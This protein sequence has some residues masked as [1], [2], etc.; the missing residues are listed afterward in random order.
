MESKYTVGIID[1]D[2]TSFTED[3]ES[4]LGKTCK[5]VSVT[6]DEI[7][8]MI[9]NNGVQCIFVI[10]KGYTDSFMEE[11]PDKLKTYYQEG[12]NYSNPILK[13]VKDYLSGAALIAS[14]S[15]D[16]ESFDWGMDEFQKEILQI[17]YLY[18]DSAYNSKTSAAITAFGYMAFCML[19][20]MTF[21]T[22]LIMEDKTT[23]VTKRL[24][25]SPVKKG[26]YYIQHLL[27][28]VL[29]AVVQTVVVIL[30]LPLLGQVSFGHT[31]LEIFRVIVICVLFSLVCISMGVAINTHA[32]SKL[33]AGSISSLINLPILML[34]GCLWPIE[35]MPDV[36][37]KIGGILPTTWFIKGASIVVY[38]GTL[39]DAL[40]YITYM[41]MFTVVVIVTSFIVKTRRACSIVK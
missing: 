41:L 5:L 40:Q 36:L 23:G 33:D 12:S 35:N 31:S 3:F 26:S 13:N 7:E 25:T 22:S 15:E 6:E 18:A 38:G 9:L 4:Y 2:Q 27:A 30:V 37:Q 32:K 8:D 28:Y 34:G 11:T 20:L 24:W 29:I 19:F 16:R 1:Y 39:Y 21:S 14:S 17:E 10:P